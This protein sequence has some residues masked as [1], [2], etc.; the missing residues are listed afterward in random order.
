MKKTVIILSI[1]ALIAGSCRQKNNKEI[2]PVLIDYK[3]DT[4]RISLGESFQKSKKII[5]WRYDWENSRDTTINAYFS[6]GEPLISYNDGEWLPA[7]FLETDKNRI[8][9]FTC[10][11]L[12]ILEKTGNPIENFLNIIGNDIK[13]LQIDTI[14]KSIISNGI[15][16]TSTE[17]YIETYKLTTK[18]ERLTFTYDLFEYT[19]KIPPDEQTH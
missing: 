17:N 5:D 6:L 4:Y 15:F 8:I 9:S 16:E 10:S 14:K 18:E 19:I 12:F 11:I 2:K 1:L 3:S 13:K 7:L